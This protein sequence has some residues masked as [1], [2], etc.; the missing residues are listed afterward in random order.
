MVVRGYC[1]RL[2]RGSSPRLASSPPSTTSVVP[3]MLEAAGEV[4]NQMASACSRDPANRCRGIRR[5]MIV[6][7]LRRDVSDQGEDP[8]HPGQLV[9]SRLVAVDGD[10]AEAAFGIQLRGGFANAGCGAGNTILAVICGDDVFGKRNIP[11][12]RHRTLSQSRRNPRP[13]P[14]TLRAPRPTTATATG[15]HR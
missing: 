15:S 14:R 2:G 1:G 5:V 13:R 12:P 10:N 4:R 6:V 9:Q 7:L 11:S 8:V 3:V